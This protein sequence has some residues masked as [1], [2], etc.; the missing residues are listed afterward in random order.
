VS[1]RSGAF[2]RSDLAANTYAVGFSGGAMRITTDGGANWRDLDPANLVPSRSVY[3]L[4]FNPT[5]ANLLYVALLGTSGGTPSSLWRTTNALNVSPAWENVSFPA[6]VPARS[7]AMDQDDPAI[8]YVGTQIGVWKTSNGGASWVHMGPEVGMPNVEVDELRLDNT[9]GRLVAFTHGRGA[10]ALVTANSLN[11]TLSQSPSI[12]PASVGCEL[13]FTLNVANLGPLDATQVTVTN[14]LPVGVTFSAATASQGSFMLVGSTVVFNVGNLALG[15]QATLSVTVLANA[16]GSLTNS[17]NVSSAQ[18]DTDPSNNLSTRVVAAQVDT[19]APRLFSAAAQSNAVTITLTFSEPV[20]APGALNPANYSLRDSRG[21]N[22]P[23]TGAAFGPTPFVVLLDAA[24]VNGLGPIVLTA[25]GLADCVGN[26]MTA[27][28]IN[29]TVPPLI[30]V[31]LGATWRYLDNGVDQGTA[32]RNRVFDDSA[33]GLGG[34]QLGYGDGDEI[35]VLNFGPDANAKYPTYYFRRAFYIQDASAWSGL[36]IRLLRDDGAVVYLNGV[37]VFRS[38]MPAGTILN[39]TFASA[40]VSGSDEATFYLSN[41]GSGSLTN[42]TNVIAVEIHQSSATSSDVSFDLELAGILRSLPLPTFGL[43]PFTQI[44]EC[45]SIVTFRA[46]ATNG[47]V[48]YQWY[49]RGLPLAGQT[50]TNIVVVASAATSGLYYEVAANSV[51]SVTSSIVALFSRDN[52]P[53]VIMSC[54]P[55]TTIAANSPTSGVVPDLTSQLVA[56]DACSGTLTILQSP[57]AGTQVGLGATNI[58]FSVTDISN[59]TAMCSAT[60]TVVTVTPPGFSMQPKSVSASAGDTVQFTCNLTNAEPV[61]FRWR[62]NGADISGAT[63]QTLILSNVQYAQAGSYSVMASNIAGTATSDGAALWFLAGI[64]SQ[65]GLPFYG[66]VGTMF[67]VQYTA[68]LANGTNAPWMTLTNFT[69]PS[70]PYYFIDPTP[71]RPPI[72]FYRAILLP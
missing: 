41:I 22:I 45:G 52:L 15:N 17:A 31:P 43:Q 32:W 19:G 35:T 38:N 61:T 68:N 10:F 14:R 37:E 63:S 28:Q 25:G 44:A 57:P 29:L 72:R 67:Q 23:I 62:F 47:L 24:I 1:Y 65:A 42:G 16:A 34:A 21:T 13:T 36:N 4:A 33:W 27:T 60:L 59:R 26:F 3:D 40:A 20:M 56:V 66:P 46:Y 50:N 30:L 58:N 39:S 71:V 51:G 54:A 2:A 12:E 69:L 53:P 48:T 18:T 70:N 9:T 8:L 6:D 7:I 55:N 64:D 11:L 49:G 5:N